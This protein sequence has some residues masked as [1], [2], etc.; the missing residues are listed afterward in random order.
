[1][2]QQE[3]IQWIKPNANTGTAN[4]A[5]IQRNGAGKTASGYI[6]GR[7]FSKLRVQF[8]RFINSTAAAGP[9]FKFWLRHCPSTNAWTSGTSLGTV[10]SGVTVTSANTQV[11][12]AYDI[13]MA[14]IGPFL[15]AKLSQTTTSGCVGV[16]CEGIRG[17]NNP[18][19]N[20]ALV[21]TTGFTSLTS[22]PASP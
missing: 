12:Y 13:D 1:M 15:V 2:Q 16:I 20:R 17:T 10:V 14:G 9:G 8:T 18:A 11:A 7:G 22:I 6:D 5:P 21:A 19:T 3:S 4:L